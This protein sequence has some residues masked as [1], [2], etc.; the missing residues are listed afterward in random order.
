MHAYLIVG[1]NEDLTY[2]KA[3]ELAQ[4]QNLNMLNFPLNKIEDVRQ[5]NRFTSFALNKP[6]AIYIKGV[7]E[8]TGEALNAFLK[9]LEEPQAN[10]VY[11]LGATSIHGLLSTIVSR[12]QVIKIGESRLRGENNEVI[13]F[14]KMNLPKRLIYITKF[15][16]RNEAELFLED[17]L[18]FLH[19]NLAGPDVDYPNVGKYLRS[20]LKTKSA[21]KANGNVLLQMTNLVISIS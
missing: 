19:N 18:Y 7:D 16:K 13:N 5:L 9:N 6:T 17:Y 14:S 8:A 11:F 15:K 1:G 20:A 21:I 3:I 4:K 12:C 10:L 2:A